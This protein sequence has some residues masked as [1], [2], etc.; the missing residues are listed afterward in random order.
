MHVMDEFTR[1]TCWSL[2]HCET[3]AGGAV[4]HFRT[5]E[6]GSLISAFGIPPATFVVRWEGRECK[7][8]FIYKENIAESCV[9][10]PQNT[11]LTSSWDCGRIQ[12][13]ADFLT[14]SYIWRIF[15]HFFIHKTDHLLK[16]VCLICQSVVL[17]PCIS[18]CLDTLGMLTLGLFY[19]TLMP[20]RTCPVSLTRLARAHVLLLQ[21]MTDRRQSWTLCR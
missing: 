19:W 6:P 9:R 2:K 11:I 18:R 7:Q 20:S 1:E 5:V 10:I 15:I 3:N 16:E 4:A 21:V 12:D 17:W 8:I 14:I 13:F